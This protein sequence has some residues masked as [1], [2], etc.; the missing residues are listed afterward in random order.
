MVAPVMDILANR[1][2]VVVLGVHKYSRFPA[3][4]FGISQAATSLINQVQKRYRAIT[5]F[6]EIRMQL[7]IIAMEKF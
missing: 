2:D 4:N 5:M 1:Y 3:N 6:L 7:K